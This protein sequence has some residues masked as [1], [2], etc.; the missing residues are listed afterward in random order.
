MADG[1]PPNHDK[2]P[3]LA[4][5]LVPSRPPPTVADPKNFSANF[6]D[7]VAT[8]LVKDP[9][10]R[11][12]ANGLAAHPFIKSSKGSAVLRERIGECF[13]HKIRLRNEKD[14]KPQF[15]SKLKSGQ[16]TSEASSRQSTLTG[17]DSCTELLHR[18]V[19]NSNSYS[20]I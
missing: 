7:F 13:L 19:P 12:T 17:E 4:M 18:F 3:T 15:G 10:L 11:F 6:N 14:N 1:L 5:Q 16:P 9:S 8:C 20:F 2:N